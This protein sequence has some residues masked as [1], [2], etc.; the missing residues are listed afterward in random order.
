MILVTGGNGF[1]GK[2]LIDFLG[3]KGDRGESYDLPDSTIIDNDKWSPEAKYDLE[4]KIKASSGVIHAA[5]IADLNES[6]KDAEKNQRINIEGTENV[7]RFC[8]AHDKLLV[9][10]STCCACP[11]K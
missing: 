9:Y 2:V 10:I 6:A 4:E 1:L 7:A 5:A 3:E 11:T 8:A